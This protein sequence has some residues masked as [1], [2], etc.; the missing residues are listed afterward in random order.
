MVHG[1]TRDLRGQWALE[2][3]RVAVSGTRRRPS[4]W[5]DQADAS[6]VETKRRALRRRGPDLAQRSLSD[7]GAVAVVAR[8][9]AA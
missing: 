2:D 4:C 3:A 1:L 5:R 6:M 9:A 8:S 7:L